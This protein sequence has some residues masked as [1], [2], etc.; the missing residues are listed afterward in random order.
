MANPS[1]SNLGAF[2]NTRRKADVLR[3]VTLKMAGSENAALSPSC[4]SK[5]LVVPARIADDVKRNALTG[6]LHWMAGPAQRQAAA[7][8]YLPIPKDGATK[9]EAAIARIH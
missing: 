4:A 8:G 1:V 5:A 3:R 9:E 7:L 6:F 2:E